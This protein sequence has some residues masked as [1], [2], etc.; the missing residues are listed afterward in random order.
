MFTDVYSS[1]CIKTCGVIK[2]FAV[3]I[4]IIDLQLRSVN[5]RLINKTSA[6]SDPLVSLPLRL[7]VPVPGK[8]RLNE[9]RIQRRN[10]ESSSVSAPWSSG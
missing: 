7:S 4:T 6:A 9:R 3:V 8:N 2:P 10:R 1:E 5:T